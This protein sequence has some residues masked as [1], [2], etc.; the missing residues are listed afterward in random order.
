MSKN[1]KK[2]HSESIV[3]KKVCFLVG[4]FSNF[5][6]I[7]LMRKDNKKMKIFET[8]FRFPGIYPLKGNKMKKFN[9]FWEDFSTSGGFTSCERKIKNENF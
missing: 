1:K 4:Y 5:R 8:V 2:N 6:G 7:Y 3:Y 9:F